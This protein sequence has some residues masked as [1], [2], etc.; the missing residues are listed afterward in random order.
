METIQIILNSRQKFSGTNGN[1]FYKLQKNYFKEGQL[2]KLK[3]ICRTEFLPLNDTAHEIGLVYMDNLTNK[4][5][6]GL[7][8]LG[9]LQAKTQFYNTNL[10]PRVSYE[11]DNEIHAYPL[12]ND[13]LNVVIK[14]DVGGLWQGGTPNYVLVLQFSPVETNK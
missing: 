8:L 9:I 2:Y 6:S 12:L 4:T 5:S 1:A 7:N 14:D 3:V 10:I 11:F 13:L